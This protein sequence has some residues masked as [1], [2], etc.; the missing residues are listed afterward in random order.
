MVGQ[1]LQCTKSCVVKVN[2]CSWAN[3]FPR[4]SRQGFRLWNI[5]QQHNY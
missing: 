2:S 3:F 5:L 4:N 1:V